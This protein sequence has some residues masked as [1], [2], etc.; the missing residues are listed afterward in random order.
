MP[1][2]DYVLKLFSLVAVRLPQRGRISHRTPNKNDEGPTIF[3]G[4]LFTRVLIP[5][6]GK[7]GLYLN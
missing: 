1:K 2:I 6:S 3:C 4:S 7:L 5:F